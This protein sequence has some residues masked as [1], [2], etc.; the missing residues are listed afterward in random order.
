[1]AHQTQ[2]D[3]LEFVN[4]LICFMEKEK[5]NLLFNGFTPD[6][7]LMELQAKSDELNDFKSEDIA[8]KA[9]EDLYV[10][11]ADMAS[12]IIKTCGYKQ[13]LLTGTP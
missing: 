1:M 10:M 7:R 12:V 9:V 13:Q 3:K 8:H 6:G 5:L 11:A 2:T 4:N